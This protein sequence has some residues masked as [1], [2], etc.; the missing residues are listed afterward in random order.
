M[1]HFEDAVFYE[2]LHLSIYCTTFK[3]HS[4]RMDIW[5]ILI[6]SIRRR[7]QLI[8]FTLE[9]YKSYAPFAYV[10]CFVIGQL[11]SFYF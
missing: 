10:K 7:K 9:V 8:L 5:F 2:F 1:K 6:V 4:V 11:K 3:V